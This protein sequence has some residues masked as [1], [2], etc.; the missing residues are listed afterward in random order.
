MQ[1]AQVFLQFAAEQLIFM[2]IGVEEHDRR[3]H[4]FLLFIHTRT[5]N[6]FCL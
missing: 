2:S 3:D 4:W 6:F 5:S 1:E